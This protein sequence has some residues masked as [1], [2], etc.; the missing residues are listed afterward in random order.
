MRL[1]GR[2]GTGVDGC[3]VDVVVEDALGT[4]AGHDVGRGTRDA[5]ADVNAEEWRSNA[6]AKDMAC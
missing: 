5:L 2:G 6:L 4:G 1:E 3:T